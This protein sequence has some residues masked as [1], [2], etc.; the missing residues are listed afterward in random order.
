MVGSKPKII[1]ELEKTLGKKFR[2]V[3]ILNIWLD[4]SFSVDSQEVVIGLN[5]EDS[6]IADLSPFASLN[7]LKVLNL[8]SNQ[9]TDLSP[10]ASLKTLTYLCLNKNQIT[11]L[12][13]LASLISL[14]QLFLDD[15]LATD[16]SPLVSLTAIISLGLSNNQITDLSPL[17]S[18][19]SLER[20]WLNENQV[21]DLSPLLHLLS[22]KKIRRCTLRNNKI[23][24]L[25][26][27][28]I[29][30]GLPIKWEYD[31]SRGLFLTGNPL[32]SPPIEIVKRGPDAVIAYFQQ[33]KAASVCL[34]QCKLL[35]VG[36]G[37]VGKT[38][39]MKKLKDPSFQ[40]E[41]GKEETTH[42]IHISPWELVCRFDNKNT[43]TVKISFWDFGGQDIYHA[44]HQFFLTKR[45]LYLLVWEARKEEDTHS[46]DYWLNV[47]KLLGSGSPVLVVMNKSDERTKSIDEATLIEKFPNIVG[48]LKVSCL[49]GHGLTELTESIRQALGTMPHIQDQLPAAWMKIR[50]DLKAREE[51]YIGSD[52]YFSLCETHGL[53]RKDAEVLS[54]YLHDLGHI[55]YFREDPLL[56]DTVILNPEWATKAVYALIDTKD[57]IDNKGS[58]YFRDLK[59]YW[60]TGLYPEQKHPQIVRLME[61]FELCFNFL[62]TDK[63]F[64][65]E[66]L[67]GEPFQ[68]DRSV[69]RQPGT[70]RFQYRYDFMPEGILSRFIARLYYLIHESR[71]WKYGVELQFETSTA[72]VLSEPIYRRVRVAVTGT[73]KSELLAI[74][75][76]DFTHIH[77]TLNMEV[78]IHYREMVPC[79]CETCSTENNP[80]LYPYDKLRKFI[81]KEKATIQ[82]LESTED[83]EIHSLIKGFEPPKPKKDLLKGVLDSAV[84]LQRL[85]LAMKPDEDSRTSLLTV[86]LKGQG[87]I[88]D[89]QGRGGRSASGKSM[90]RPDSMIESE[91]GIEAVL[92]AFRLDSLVK[93]TIDLHCLKIFEYDPHGL[94]RNFIIVY[95][96]SKDFSGLWKK[97][98]EHLKEIPYPYPLLPK[99]GI[100]EKPV[101]YAEIRV[102]CTYHRRET[103][104]TSIYHIFINMNPK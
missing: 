17:A 50:D 85:T 3:D 9:I 79:T 67:P 61:K 42:G 30:S 77:D 10:L 25:P 40:V 53:D 28:I 89:D 46:F 49:Q 24:H 54:D 83:V 87:F 94:K 43:G 39:L 64:I 69:Y 65:P 58:F 78:P 86:L 22:A 60:D 75:R 6:G 21:S 14:T 19:K 20:L 47:V 32:E 68:F 91:Q 29:N 95:S 62:H 99:K 57:I 59:Q 31:L 81:E 56:A 36:N 45:S 26:P 76:S 35:I 63:Y 1:E 98:K 70:L 96:E 72:L 55:L 27:E 51:D 104:K 97:Y 100:E 8:E 38:T 101:T 82:C 5:L 88:V 13:P 7:A 4:N 23:T 73:C 102:A 12:S 90:G 34:L 48:F 44:T 93:D 92:E 66:L 71:F 103:M 74:I 18:L 84:Q 11:D 37:E 52:R 33:L 16:L 41:L 2:E 15:N 80:Y